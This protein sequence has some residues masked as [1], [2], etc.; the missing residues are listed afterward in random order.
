MKKK[1]K[2]LLIISIILLLAEA[3][4]YLLFAVPVM[5]KVRFFRAVDE[6][7]IEKADRLLGSCFGVT[8]LY[9]TNDIDDFISYKAYRYKAGEISYIEAENAYTAIEHMEPYKGRTEEKALEINKVELPRV[10]LDG[11]LDYK[12]NSYGDPGYLNKELQ[13]RY[14]NAYMMESYFYYY[15][16]N[17]SD[18][19]SA[20]LDAYMD[21][22]LK[23]KFDAFNDG[24]LAYDDMN[25][26]ITVSETYFTDS[27]YAK[28][29]K[30][31]LS[32]AD[33]INSAYIRAVAFKDEG[34]Y[35]GCMDEA[36][37]AE[38]DYADQKYYSMY[39]ERFALLIEEAYSLG[40]E[41]YPERVRELA[42]ELK[43][44]D[45]KELI[46][47]IE[48]VYKND[49]DLDELRALTVPDYKAVYKEYLSDLSGNLK[50]SLEENVK[51]EGRF[52]SGD[53]SLDEHMP[54]VIGLKDYNGDGVPEMLI[55]DGSI[56]YTFTADFDGIIFMGAFEAYGYTEKGIIA[57]G[58]SNAVDLFSLEMEDASWKQ[59]L[60]LQ[61]A[62]GENDTHTYYISGE[63][64]DE[65][66]Y[67]A[68]LDELAGSR[69]ESP[70]SDETPI[71]DA[72]DLI[73]KY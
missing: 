2:A 51:I 7:D 71:G 53:I 10:I 1:G 38:R 28:K 33:A 45:A 60:S 30:E 42:N 20:E 44:D 8:K 23:G 64:V 5:N 18:D 73:D 72:A 14:S 12:T 62:A 58:H 16:E 70:M 49:V 19:Y 36:E 17:Y 9:I 65:D 4:A 22:W 6:Y 39:E 56:V 31:E 13:I 67:N 63:V 66:S 47:R 69:T 34:D 24:D 11:A 41:A 32:G 52:A 43:I 26:I 3:A 61:D 57:Q 48:K 35:F 55:S 25:A 46:D 40:K 21:D 15:A 29:L 68:K 37:K 59:V 54:T 50:K 27:K